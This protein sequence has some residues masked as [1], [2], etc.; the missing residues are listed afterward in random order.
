MSAMIRLQLSSGGRRFL[1][2]HFYNVVVTG[3][4][5]IIVFFIAIP[6]II[7]GFGNW[8]IPLLRG[9][10]DIVFPRLNNFSFWLVPFSFLFLVSRTFLDGVGTG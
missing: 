1:S 7:G 5:L 8:L 6:V 2:E 10:V 4:G 9:S 3:H